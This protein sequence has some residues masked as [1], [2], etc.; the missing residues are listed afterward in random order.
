MH[1]RETGRRKIRVLYIV[2]S[3]AVGGAQGQLV[4]LATRLDKERFD[5][6][7]CCLTS[8]GPWQEPLDA[9]GIPVVTI[10]FRGFGGLVRDPA[11]VFA[12]LLHL[13]RTIRSFR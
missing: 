10:G 12:P 7:V 5:V 4:H 6:A 3:L 1:Q 11:P 8:S 9:A 13:I 2:S